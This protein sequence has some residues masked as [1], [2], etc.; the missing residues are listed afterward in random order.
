MYRFIYQIYNKKSFLS[1]YH[2]LLSLN[3][4]Q[5]DFEAVAGLPNTATA[6]RI[7][8]ISAL[9]KSDLLIECETGFVPTFPILT[10]LLGNKIASYIK[11][12]CQ[13]A[14]SKIT[15]QLGDKIAKS[16][17][18]TLLINITLG[19]LWQAILNRKCKTGST[20]SIVLLREC[21]NNPT[22]YIDG[23]GPGLGSYITWAKTPLQKNNKQLNIAFGDKHVKNTFH[24]IKQDGS[25]IPY[26]NA[27]EKL[28]ALKI[29]QLTSDP[30][31]P[32]SR[33]LLA[34]PGITPHIIKQ[35]KHDL[36]DLSIIG[37]ESI[38]QI[39]KVSQ[40]AYTN[41][42]KNGIVS[43]I[44]FTQAMYYVYSN[45]LVKQLINIGYMPKLRAIPTLV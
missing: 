10:P 22:L 38:E 14:A 23:I 15:A 28:T 35:L 25:M 3:I 19:Y 5:Q 29:A 4:N 43:K 18:A 20:G 32:V 21:E 37:V 11:K 45:E 34:E 17:R 2:N 9:Q 42:M 16:Y 39:A 33:L 12:Y 30:N 8:I 6:L 7:E 13:E 36:V 40:Q 27:R 26:G 24:S 31:N 41:L 1:N 44:Y